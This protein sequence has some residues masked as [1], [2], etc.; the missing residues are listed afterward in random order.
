MLM[1]ND[2]GL[3]MRV[4]RDLQRREGGTIIGDKLFPLHNHLTALADEAPI[5]RTI[6]DWYVLEADARQDRQA[7][8]SVA[9]GAPPS[10]GA[11]SFNAGASAPER[12]AVIIIGSVL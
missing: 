7:V 8:R 11:L 12:Q 9:A 2:D 1:A 5:C 3:K 4:L 6:G 10:R